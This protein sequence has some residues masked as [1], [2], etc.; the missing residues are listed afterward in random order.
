MK[1]KIML[2]FIVFLFATLSAFADTITLKSGKKIEG[3]ILE[4]TSDTVKVDFFGVRL[5]FFLKDIA[6]IKEDNPLP[7]SGKNV[8]YTEPKTE[9]EVYQEK[10][11]VS[12][13]AIPP[14]ESRTTDVLKRSQQPREEPISF[15]NKER[16]PY[17]DATGRNDSPVSKKTALAAFAFAGV[18]IFIFAVIG[19]IYLSLCVQFIAKKTNQEPAWLAWIP[20]ANL[21]LMC[22]IAGLSY[23]WLL[24][25][26]AGFI[27]IIGVLT[28][29]AFTGFLWYRIALVRNKPGWLGILCFV[30]LVNLVVMGYLAFSD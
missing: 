9:T 20:I 6:E 8:L 11:Q 4:K 15:G 26:F 25:I 23:W 30:P 27:P 14:A 2:L 1:K 13:E 12:E 17:R 22:K 10:P 24:I 29:L 5:V 3:K 19:Y 28:S 21:F 16:S 7:I 18:I